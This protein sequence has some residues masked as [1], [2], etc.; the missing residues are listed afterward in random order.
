MSGFSMAYWNP[1]SI[2]PPLHPWF[3]VEQSTRFCSEREVSP[4][5]ATALA[6]SMA[7]VVEKA[8]HDPHCPWFLTGV[9]APLDLQSTVA[10]RLSSE[11]YI[12]SAVLC[13]SDAL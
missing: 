7:P 6:P 11:I 13:L 2:R 1:R 8:Q 10:S 9:T 3:L 12:G 4:D 5:P